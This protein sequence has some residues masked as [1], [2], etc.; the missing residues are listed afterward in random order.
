M[1]V[2]I[3]QHFKNRY[4]ECTEI[5]FLFCP[6]S[7]YQY[8]D[9]SDTVY[10]YNKCLRD[11]LALNVFLYFM[12]LILF[13]IICSGKGTAR[14]PEVCVSRYSWNAMSYAFKFIMGWYDST[15]LLK[16]RETRMLLVYSENRKSY[17]KDSLVAKKTT[18]VTYKV[19]RLE[20]PCM[21][22][23]RLPRETCIMSMTTR[24]S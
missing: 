22:N 19:L 10:F 9:I 20:I 13:L 5:S 6:V 14:V 7:V 2:I 16:L 23:K 4:E 18:S 24:V 12:A 17:S 8:V 15:A 1:P 11:V 3:R 21:L